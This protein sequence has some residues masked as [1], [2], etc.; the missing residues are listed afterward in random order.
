MPGYDGTGPRGTGQPGRGQGRR[1]RHGQGHA[2]QPPFEGQGYFYEYTL[3]ELRE[4]KQA[5]E[6]EIRWIEDR[7]KELVEPDKPV[8]V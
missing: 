7:I 5:L 3:E 4:R 1:N 2:G 8:D 6:E